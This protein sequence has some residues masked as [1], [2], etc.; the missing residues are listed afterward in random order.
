MVSNLPCPRSCVVVDQKVLKNSSRLGDIS[1]LVGYGT[2]EAVKIVADLFPG[3]EVVLFE[4][5]DRNELKEEIVGKNLKVTE[6]LID[7]EIIA[8]Q[9]RDLL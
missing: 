4:C 6:I 3:S 7:C 5:K 2:A 1:R 8:G 9:I